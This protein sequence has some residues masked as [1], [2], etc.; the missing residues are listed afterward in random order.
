MREQVF[1][2]EY[3][4]EEHLTATS[5]VHTL[6]IRSDLATSIASSGDTMYILNP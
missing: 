3:A 1:R 5:N 6:R 2:S 4:F